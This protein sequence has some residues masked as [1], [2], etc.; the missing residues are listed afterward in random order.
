M[1]DS[2][3]SELS[4]NMHFD[5]RYASILEI[6]HNKKILQDDRRERS[7]KLI[8]IPCYYEDENECF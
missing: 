6:V 4:I 3:I 8:Y 1:C 5:L 7:S 2:E